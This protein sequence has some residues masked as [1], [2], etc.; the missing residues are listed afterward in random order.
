MNSKELFE[1]IKC[2]EEPLILT[3]FEWFLFILVSNN[4]KFDKAIQAVEN[5]RN[6]QIL[7]LETLSCCSREKLENIIKASGFY[8]SKAKVMLS[9][10]DEILSQYSSFEGFC[11][12]ASGEWLYSQKGLGLKSADMILLF[13]CEQNVMPVSSNALKILN[14]LGYEFESYF[15]AREWLDL[16]NIEISKAYYISIENFAKRHF[17]GRQIL[18]SGAKILDNLK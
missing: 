12:D 15:E 16:G 8:K 11:V 4:T 13:V 1:L 3:K 14:Y 2:E 18:P 17:K 5:L 10:A 6:F 7:D 9:L